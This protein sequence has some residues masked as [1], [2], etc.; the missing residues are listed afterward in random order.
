M[1]KLAEGQSMAEKAESC[2]PALMPWVTPYLTVKD[3]S[4]AIAFYQAAFGFSVRDPVKDDAGAVVHAELTLGRE[5]ALV[6]IGAEGRYGGTAKAPASGGFESPVS[7]YFYVEDVETLCAR[8][9]AAGAL[10]VVPPQETHW[11]D[12]MCLLVDPDGHKWNFATR[13]APGIVVGAPG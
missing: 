5:H 6:M 13:L 8:A 3:C 1:V 9:V 4:K 2:K 10:V 11:G 12:R 7:L